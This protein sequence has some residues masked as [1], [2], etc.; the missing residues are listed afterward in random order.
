MF[1]LHLLKFF[2][3]LKTTLQSNYIFNE[4]KLQFFSPV[5]NSIEN[6][7]YFEKFCI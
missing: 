1:V 5:E 6:T 3:R 2:I 7:S 4:D